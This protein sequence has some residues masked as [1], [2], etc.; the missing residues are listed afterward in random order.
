LLAGVAAADQRAPELDALFVALYTADS[1]AEAG[2]VERRIWQLWGRS[3]DASVDARL[4]QGVTAMG[5]GD[6]EGAIDHFS[7]VVERAPRFAEGWNKRAT[8]YYL[9]DQYAASM[10]DIERTLALEPRHFGA[11]S[12]MGLIFLRGGDLVGALAAFERVLEIHPRSPSARVHVRRIRERLRGR[13][14]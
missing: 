10:A 13:A 2:V 1:A 7:H 5:G 4:A 12:G 3:G 9:S 11:M 6:L 14:A 8:A